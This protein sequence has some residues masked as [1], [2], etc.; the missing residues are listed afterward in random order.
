MYS[1]A[2]ERTVAF[3]FLSA[4]IPLKNQNLKDVSLARHSSAARPGVWGL[5]PRNTPSKEKEGKINH[6]LFNLCAGVKPCRS[7]P[8]I[9]PF[10]V[11]TLNAGTLSLSAA[12]LSLRFVR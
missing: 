3:L 11:T 7:S 8:S 9:P 10:L 4:F 1:V 6:T 12:I 2:L 5:P